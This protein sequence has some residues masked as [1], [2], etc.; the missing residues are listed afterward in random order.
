MIGD[1]IVHAATIL[2]VMSVITSSCEPTIVE[3][4]DMI[5]VN[6]LHTLDGE[7][8]FTQVIFWKWYED[9]S[10]YHC[11]AWTMN[12]KLSF[13][14]KT[15]AFMEGKTPRRVRATHMKESWTQYDPERT[16]KEYVAET[17]RVKLVQRALKPV[18][19]MILPEV[20]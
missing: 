19:P 12:E 5:E 18:E 8:T 17:D 16:D 15:A 9:K 10:E 3:H 7:P 1:M 20:E 4:T 13:N 2:V 14:G 11:R 6:H